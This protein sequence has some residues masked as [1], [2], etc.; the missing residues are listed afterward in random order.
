MTISTGTVNTKEEVWYSMAEGL[1]RAQKEGVCELTPEAKAVCEK[2]RRDSMLMKE[3]GITP[4]QLNKGQLEQ[5]AG[6]TQRLVYEAAGKTA[7]SDL[8]TSN[9][10]TD[11]RLKASFD[12]KAN[13]RIGLGKWMANGGTTAGSEEPSKSPDKTTSTNKKV[14][15]Q[16]AKTKNDTTSS[17]DSGLAAVKAKAT[18]YVQM[19]KASTEDDSKT[20]KGAVGAAKLGE[21]PFSFAST[22]ESFGVGDVASS[23]LPMKDG[24]T[25]ED[26]LLENALLA[27]IQE[28]TEALSVL[29]ALVKKDSTRETNMSELGDNIAAV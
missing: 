25:I 14:S 1:R 24:G 11:N 9:G 18:D 28:L 3:A 16:G 15:G 22:G 10:I 4:D 2:G 12:F 23:I 5:I 29:A 7:P 21:D 6:Y 20:I 8:P 19:A 13:E 26:A 17:A 27:R